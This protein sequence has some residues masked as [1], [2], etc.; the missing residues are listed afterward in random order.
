MCWKQDSARTVSRVRP[1]DGLQKAP[2]C[3]G[4]SVLHPERRRIH[5]RRRRGELRLPDWL[6]RGRLSSPHIKAALLSGDVRDTQGW[7]RTRRTQDGRN[8]SR[9][10]RTEREKH[11]LL[12]LQ[13]LVAAEFVCSLLLSHPLSG[14]GPSAGFSPVLTSTSGNYNRRV[15][16]N[17]AFSC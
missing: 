3:W 5:P 2:P 13:A 4:G 11:F 16:W 8:L 12:L 9:G 17:R 14:P 6:E 15:R 1:M 7:V 10:R